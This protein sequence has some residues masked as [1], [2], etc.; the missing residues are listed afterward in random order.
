MTRDFVVLCYWIISKKIKI[1]DK[2]NRNLI[3]RK[4][5]NHVIS[6]SQLNVYAS[7]DKVYFPVNDKLVTAW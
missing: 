3:T 5:G 6:T 1:F 2:I 4:I 7:K